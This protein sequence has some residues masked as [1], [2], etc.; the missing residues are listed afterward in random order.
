VSGASLN[1][2]PIPLVR[3]WLPYLREVEPYLERSRAT[4]TFANHGP[5]YLEAELLLGKISGG[6][7]LP[8][9]N[10]TVAIQLALQ[11]T[12]PV[13]ARVAL[14]DYTHIGTLNAIIAAHMRPIFFPVNPETWTISITELQKHW[15]KWDAAVVV[16][17]FGY[18]V[19][20]SGYDGLGKPLVYDF[21]GGFGM[22]P[23]TPHPVCYSFHATKAFSC[24]EGGMVRF[25][26]EAQWANARQL[27]NF[28]NNPDRSI[29]NP[30]G[31]NHKIDELRAAVILCQ[32]SRYREFAKRI[33]SRV[34]WIEKYQESLPVERH[35]LHVG[36]AAPSL[37]VV[38]LRVPAAPI[39]SYLGQLQISAR[40][41][42]P[43]L[44]RMPGLAKLERVAASSDVMTRHLALPSDPTRKEFDRV[45][46]AIKGVLSVQ[47]RGA[48]A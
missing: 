24:G 16:S 39:E 34:F 7:A 6:Y 30:F 1:L 14:P 5:A 13:G 11:A 45:V 41:Y 35:V 2:S 33:E 8:V 26:S 29:A 3:P 37:C 15:K 40:A 42:Y 21:A 27:A 9:T 19:H 18:Q 12:L 10:G 46:Q 48:D 44:S 20:T 17:P 31:G 28:S 38:R 4:N 36:R 47:N 25:S 32:L 43:L 22:F 23:K